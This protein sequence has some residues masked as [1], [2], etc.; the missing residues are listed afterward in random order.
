MKDTPDPPT[1]NRPSMH[2][3][4]EE[5]L[6]FF[7]DDGTPDADKRETIEA[8]WFIMNCF[9]DSHWNTEPTAKSS[10]K[11]YELTAVLHQ[12]VLNS[13]HSDKEAV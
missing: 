13:T 9:A 1:D 8:L 12:A 2:L 6:P 3:N 5:W 7:E 11:D 10:G 4:W